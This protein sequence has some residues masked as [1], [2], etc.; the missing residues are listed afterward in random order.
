MY[1]AELDG[2][3]YVWKRIDETPEGVVGTLIGYIRDG[4]TYSY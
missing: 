3:I 4:Q 2:T 1:T